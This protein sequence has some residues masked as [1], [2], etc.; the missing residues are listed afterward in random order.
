[1]RAY[2]QPSIGTMPGDAI[3]YVAESFS[4]YAVSS[5]LMKQSLNA[6]MSTS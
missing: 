3:R 4:S 5:A 2:G 6:M 1:M